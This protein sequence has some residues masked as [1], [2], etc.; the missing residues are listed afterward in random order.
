MERHNLFFTGGFDST[1]RLC[2]LS[3]MDKPLDFFKM[4]ILQDVV[5]AIAG[6]ATN[7][8][9]PR[10]EN[11]KKNSSLNPDVIDFFIPITSVL[12]RMGSTI[13]VGI[14]IVFAASIFHITLSW[15]Q[16]VVASLL[17]FIALMCAPGIIGGTLMD[18][19]ITWSAIGIPIEAIA[20]IA[21]ID[22]VID[23]IRTVLNI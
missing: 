11:L 18:C 6:G 21:G 23:V 2:Q 16:I 7:Y 13:C 3:R 1:F 15:E 10:I 20:Y 19:A 22:Y 8:M 12:T 17:T 14:Y 9:A 5:G 4:I